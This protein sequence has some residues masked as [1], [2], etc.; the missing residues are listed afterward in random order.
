VDV[1]STASNF[2]IVDDPRFA[3]IEADWRLTM[4][5]PLSQPFVGG[6]MT[7][8]RATLMIDPSRRV[9]PLVDE[10][11]MPESDFASHAPLLSA[12]KVTLGNEVRLK[13]REASVQLTGVLEVGGEITNPYISGEILADR[14]TYRVDLGLLK[15]TFRVD[16]G[17]VRVAGT[18]E[19]PVALDIWTSYLVRSQDRDDVKIVAHVTGSTLAPHLEL[20]SA[21]L[22]TGSSQSEIISYLVFGSPT[23]GLDGQGGSAV[24]TATAALVPSL[25][26][27]LEGTLGTLL[28]FLSSLQ[29]TTVAGN[30][31]QSLAASPL[32]GLLNS[33]A[34]TAGRQL[35]SDTFLSL[36]AGM[37]RG[38]RLSSAS[39]TSGWFGLG[40]EY[41]PHRG[42]GVALSMDPGASP[43]NR[44]GKFLD[45]YQFGVDL[46]REWKVR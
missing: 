25:G 17:L 6:E 35:G 1:T 27:V 37:C 28:P 19:T 23:F 4:R 44:V 8:P 40:A 5:G 30:G 32:D 45:V 18:R 42:P 10:S 11:G 39:S 7:L 34:L 22:G 9:R 12:L 33:F 21:D 13:S 41:R 3:Q 24:K 20:S 31:P 46:V 36:S 29:V 26:G 15:R 38:S 16:S 14:G 43:C 2:S